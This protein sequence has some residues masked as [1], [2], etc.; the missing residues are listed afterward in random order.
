MG[1]C[2][3]DKELQK[4]TYESCEKYF[5]DLQIDKCKIVKYVDGDT[6]HIAWRSGPKKYVRKCVRLHGINCPEMKSENEDEVKESLVS[7]AAFKKA[8]ENKI[9]SCVVHKT[10]KPDP[11]G[12]LLVT[13]ID[14]EKNI[15]EWMVRERYASVYDGKR[16]ARYIPNYYKNR[17]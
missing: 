17:I 5:P 11:Y 3:S 10:V 6:C 8:T 7:L 9:L 4:C 15:N 1:N 13:L 16:K 12:R 2:I 14:G